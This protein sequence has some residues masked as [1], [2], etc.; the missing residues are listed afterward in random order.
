MRR[1]G[2]LMVKEERRGRAEWEWKTRGGG[3]DSK[4]Y[5]QRL[6]VVGRESIEVTI[7]DDGEVSPTL[8]SQQIVKVLSLGIEIE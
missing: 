7:E 5:L 6:K 2:W 3:P 4:E 8:N 1:I